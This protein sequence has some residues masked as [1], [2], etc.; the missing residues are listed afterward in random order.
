[1]L[2]SC[3]G[4]HE[5]GLESVLVSSVDGRVVWQWIKRFRQRRKL[6]PVRVS[7]V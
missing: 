2:Q 7:G 6:I 5:L 4:R 1:V 3:G